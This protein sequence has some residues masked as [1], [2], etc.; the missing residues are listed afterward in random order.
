MRIL[1]LG[2][3]ALKDGFRELGH[4]VLTCPSDNTGDIWIPEVPISIERLL[5]Q[6]PQ[7]WDPDFVLLIDESTH[8]LFLG[9]ERLEI[10]VA[11]YAIDSHIHYRWHQAYA[12]AFDL[13][14]VAQ[15]D[16]V[17]HYVRDQ[18]RQIAHWLPLFPPVI[19]LLD[20][21]NSRTFNLSF[22]G[23][24]NPSLNPQRYKFLEALQEA[25][26]L[27][28]ATGDYLS[29]FQQSQMILNQSVDNDVNFRTFEAM[30]CGGLLLM[31]RV[32]N[33]LEDLFQ[34]RTHCV[35]YEK[36]NIEEVVDIAHF[37]ASH[38]EEREAIAACGREEMLAKHTAVHRAQSILDTLASIDC[39]AV[40]QQK[41]VRQGEI[42]FL[43]A[44][45]YEHVAMC[46]ERA[47]GRYPTEHPMNHRWS[48]LAEKFRHISHQIHQ[49]LGV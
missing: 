47:K 27:Y 30:A 37:Y 29:V 1:L 41:Q 20:N 3:P 17:T 31:E 33:G 44:P 22:V 19:P 48:A 7:G 23:N 8:P 14:F 42:L 12:A 10:P 9:L 26:P 45:V 46:Y 16:F 38:V 24:V 15:R 35:M 4:E 49:E 5:Q 13:I 40:I 28:V 6:L 11:W 25:Y 32:G 2:L 39:Q 21:L 18:S 43:L 34:D 36:G